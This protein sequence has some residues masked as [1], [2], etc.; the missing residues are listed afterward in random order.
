MRCWSELGALGCTGH[1]QRGGGAGPHWA[2]ALCRGPGQRRR[3]RPQALGTGPG[4][5]RRSRA[6]APAPGTGPGHRHQPRCP[7][8]AVSTGA[9]SG[10]APCAGGSG[11]RRG[12]ALPAGSPSRAGMGESTSPI[13][14][15]LVSS[16][17]RGNK[18]LFRF[19]F[20]RCAEHPAAQ[21]S[22]C[23]AGSCGCPAPLRRGLA[24][25]HGRGRYPTR[26]PLTSFTLAMGAWHPSHCLWIPGTLH[27]SHCLCVSCTPHTVSGYLAALT[28]AGHENLAPLTTPHGLC[29]SQPLPCMCPHS[30]QV[31]WELS[32][33]SHVHGTSQCL[34][35]LSIIMVPYCWPRGR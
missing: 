27:P 19:P 14:V 1:G 30:P 15:I 25:S 7:G 10:P 29:T 6:E 17:S 12:R 35:S 4:Q 24:S 33:P 5:R 11:R 3:P 23:R 18:L 28:H 16:G 2:Q 31:P 13:S 34:V 32:H 8:R 21:D 20:Q 9:G 22:K 26:T